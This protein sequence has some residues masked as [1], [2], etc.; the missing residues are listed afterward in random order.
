MNRIQHHALTGLGTILLLGFLNP[1]GH[2]LTYQWQM[3]PVGSSTFSNVAGASLSSYTTPAT[4]LTDNGARFRVVVT[5]ATGSTTS[6]VSTLAVNGPPPPPTLTYQWQKAAAGSSTFSNIVGATSASYTTPATLLTDNG[7]QFRVVITNA[8]GSTTS[9]A[10]TLTVNGPPPPPTLTYQWQKTAAGSSTFSNIVGAT[11][12]SYATPAALLTDN[13]AQFR[14]VVTNASG[15]TTSNASTLT[16]NGPPP[17]PTLTYQWQKAPAGSSTFTNIAG[18]ASSTYATPTALITDNGAQFR[19]VVANGSGS[20]TSSASTLTVIGPPPPPPALTYQWQKAPAGSST[21]TNIAGASSST[22]TT[23]TALITENGA[24]FRVVVTNGSGSTTSS[25]STLTV[26]GPPPPPPA[27][28]Y[29]WQMAPPGSIFFRNI[30]GA[31]SS[32]YTTPA[33]S[34]TDN[35][36]RFRVVVTN[37]TGSTTSNVSTLTVNGPPPPPPPPTLTYQWQRASAGSAFFRNILGATSSTYTTR[38]ALITDNGTQFRVVVTNGLGSTTS[39][40][41]ILTVNGPP[42]P[43]PPPPTLTYQWQIAPA[44][45]STFSDIAGASSSSYTTPAALFADNGAQFRVVVTNAS[46]S[47]ISDPSTLTVNG[48]PSPGPISLPAPIL[49]NFQAIMTLFDTL[50]IQA[51]YNVP[52]TYNWTFIKV[53]SADGFNMAGFANSGRSANSVGAA[54]QASSASNAL[55]V[56]SLALTPGQY[57]V[58]VYVADTTGNISPTTTV[59]VTF[60]PGEFSGARVFPNPWRSDRNP[61]PTMTFDRMPPN[62]TVKIYTVSGRFVKTLSAPAGSVSWDLKNDSGDNVG[63]GL[64]IYIISDGSN[65]NKRG[66]LAIIR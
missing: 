44:G 47:T 46:G 17:P 41:S 2:A 24:Q 31:S 50:E 37:G 30:A 20:T 14:V 34:L 25:A 58:S 15:S 16:V 61:P 21:F 64:Y 5:N 56:P 42:P 38:A 45:S 23:P 52:V 3:S 4:L 43:P 7:A 33:T 26:I 35:G 1:L 12:S 10:S 51:Q 22:Y 60:L 28:T 62:S 57:Q 29:Q 63:S 39:D 6:N 18:A 11:S 9:N 66:Q 65:A 55:S 8:S 13:G 59:N 27:L 32:T 49:E 54:A 36:A 48:P 53:G 19:V 40:V